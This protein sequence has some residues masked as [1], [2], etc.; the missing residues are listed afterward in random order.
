MFINIR[1]RKGLAYHIP[2]SAEAYEDTGYFA[3]QAGFDKDKVYESL[4]AV[5]AELVKVARHG[6]TRE[7]FKRAKDNVRGRLILNFE[8]PSAYLS[9][10]M[11]QDLLT[12]SVD[13]LE[14]TLAKIA[15]VSIADVNRVA[16]RVISLRK[17]NLAVIGPYKDK[18]K[19]FNL[20][21]GK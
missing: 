3:V 11:A 17:A 5:K 9:Y 4:E 14:A 10:L 15:K 12:N 6:V 16:R 8:Q 13:S 7:E 1:E 2:S 19:F 20:L 21:T 18:K